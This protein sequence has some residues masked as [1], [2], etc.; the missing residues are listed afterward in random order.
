VTSTT[1]F[2]HHRFSSCLVSR[3]VWCFCFWRPLVVFY[4]SLCTSR[5]GSHCFFAFHDLVVI[6][7]QIC[8]GFFSVFF[9]WVSFFR[10]QTDPS[11]GSE[12]IDGTIAPRIVT[13]DTGSWCFGLGFW[14]WVLL[15]FGCEI[16]F[17]HDCVAATLICRKR[18]YSTKR[19]SAGRTASD[20]E[21]FANQVL[22]FWIVLWMALVRE[23]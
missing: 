17:L 11:V 3:S 10:L 1:T 22:G 20:S 4:S 9:G 7:L 15:R 12:T 2:L 6:C 14:R 21:E 8:G 13:L 16:F 19:V 18:R 5:I 23:N